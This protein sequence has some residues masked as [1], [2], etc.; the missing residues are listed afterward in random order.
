MDVV[1]P[2]ILAGP[3]RPL[4]EVRVPALLGEGLSHAGAGRRTQM[5]EA[6][7]KTCVSR[8]PARPACHNR[9]RAAPP[10]RNAG[11]GG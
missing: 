3:D 7:V 11:M 9:V 1:L 10:A 4:R 2:D 6:L 5:S 8:I